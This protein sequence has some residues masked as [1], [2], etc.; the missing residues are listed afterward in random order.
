MLIY[1]LS[2]H[3]ND[4]ELFNKQGINIPRKLKEFIL[5]ILLGPKLLIPVMEFLLHDNSD[6]VNVLEW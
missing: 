3:K 6:T 1:I 2:S 5:D 4:N